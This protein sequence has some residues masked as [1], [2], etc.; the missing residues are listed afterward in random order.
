MRHDPSIGWMVDGGPVGHAGAAYWWFSLSGHREPGSIVLFCKCIW[1]YLMTL[2]LHVLY[3]CIYRIAQD[4]LVSWHDQARPGMATGV[5]EK[6]LREDAPTS[7]LALE[8]TGDEQE[9][10]CVLPASSQ[11]C[12]V[13]K[14]QGSLRPKH[15]ANSS[16]QQACKP[17]S[18]LALTSTYGVRSIRT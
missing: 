15:A 7:S 8:R 16:R 5:R 11:L 2:S 13:G 14:G 9:M 3:L 1:P 6:A 12:R 4:P 17:F 18:G 10:S